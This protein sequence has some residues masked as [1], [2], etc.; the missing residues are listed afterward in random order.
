M[1]AGIVALSVM[2]ARAAE[3]PKAEERAVELTVTVIQATEAGPTEID[4]ALERFSEL[5]RKGRFA[6]YKRFKRVDQQ[7]VRLAGSQAVRVS[8]PEAREL[9]LSH[10]GTRDGL[11]HVQLRLDG[12]FVYKVKDGGWFVHVLA[13]FGGGA[14]VVPVEARLL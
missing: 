3:T 2:P 11:I 4:P 10:Q 14:L 12:S 5:F 13:P 1:A 8:L 7:T 9:A 6:A